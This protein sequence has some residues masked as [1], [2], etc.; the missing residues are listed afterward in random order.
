M[1]EISEATVTARDGMIKDFMADRDKE[2][3]DWSRWNLII[4]II[5]VIPVRISHEWLEKD[6]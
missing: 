6:V 5:V 2:H 1:N 4:G 3:S